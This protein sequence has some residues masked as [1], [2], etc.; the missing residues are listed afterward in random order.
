MESG[1]GAGADVVRALL[2]VDFLGIS[3][4]AGIDE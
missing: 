3:C 1:L 2:P 4:W